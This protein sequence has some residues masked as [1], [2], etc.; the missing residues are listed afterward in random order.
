[1]CKKSNI[2]FLKIFFGLW[3]LCS[4]IIKLLSPPPRLLP[5]A[6]IL[7][8]A[9]KL[10][11]FFLRGCAA[12]NPYSL[13][14]TVNFTQVIVSV[15]K[16]D[17]RAQISEVT[18]VR[19]ATASSTRTNIFRTKQNYMNSYQDATSRTSWSCWGWWRSTGECRM[20]AIHIKLNFKTATTI[21][22]LLLEVLKFTMMWMAVPVGVPRLGSIRCIIEY[23]VIFY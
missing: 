2:L 21:A 18:K 12:K 5:R 14:K 16:L 8:S 7:N 3:F 1:M 6:A 22:I 10:A 9:L 13:S 17:T 19:I 23:Q 20:L 4:Y 15:L 11:G